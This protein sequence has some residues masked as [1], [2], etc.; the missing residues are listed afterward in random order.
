MAKILVNGERCTVC[1][2]LPRD[3]YRNRRKSVL[4]GGRVVDVVSQ[5]R[6]W[7]VLWTGNL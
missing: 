6:Q 4:L 7:R 3:K 2:N 5:D 1:E